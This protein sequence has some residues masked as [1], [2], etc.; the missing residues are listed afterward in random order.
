MT[1]PAGS[2]FHDGELAVQRRAGVDTAAARLAG[3]LRPADLRGGATY[4]LAERTFAAITARDTAGRLWIS[5][6]T[7]TPGFLQARGASTL[8]ISAVPLP[9]DP[10][11]RLHADQPVGLLAI[12]F[13]TR[14]R[15]RINGTLMSVDA[16]GLGISVDQAYGNCPQYIQQRRLEPVG[17]ADSSAGSAPRQG[18][19]LT[20]ADV[21]LIERADTFVLGTTHPQRGNDAS[22]RGGSPGFVRV[23]SGAA[24][25]WWPDYPGNN[26]FNSLG[27]LVSDNAAAL[28][29]ADF[30]TGHTLHLSGTATL[31]WTAP[32]SAGDDGD[33]GRR[34]LFSIESLVAGQL[35]GMRADGVGY[36]PANPPLSTAGR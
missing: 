6:L 29:F 25:L 34:V 3:M 11:H 4:F 19:T 30:A 23:G 31:G 13:A 28:L 8:V 20:A 15:F 33:T 24:T 10:L 18:S 35:L 2:G 16:T 27:N 5:P 12:D 17:G 32:G 14:R 9:G 21:D 7:G 22:H 1:S 36:S 26:L